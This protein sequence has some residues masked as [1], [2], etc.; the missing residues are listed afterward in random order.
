MAS[1]IPGS[2]VAGWLDVVDDD[3]IELGF[4]GFQFQAEV[5]FEGG[6]E[7]GGGELAGGAHVGRGEFEAD[8]EFV[9]EASLVGDDGAPKL[10]LK[11]CGEVGRGNSPPVSTLP[12]PSLG[13]L[14]MLPPERLPGVIRAIPEV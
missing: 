5:F 1:G 11:C 12:R 9:G 13:G 8:V 3:A 4:G 7:A 2:V 10:D 14:V 6:K